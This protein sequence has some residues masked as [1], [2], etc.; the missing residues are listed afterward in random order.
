MMREGTIVDAT[1]IAA[2]PLRTNKDGKRNPKM[3][4]L[5]KGSD[6]HFGMKA[7][8]GV[9]AAPRLGHTVVGTA[10]NVADLTKARTLLHGNDKAGLGD[11]GYHAVESVSK[12][13]ATP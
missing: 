5:K 1:L 11:A 6:W 4:Q 12:I 10:G 8:I 9:D 7:H 13:S 3:R 2:P